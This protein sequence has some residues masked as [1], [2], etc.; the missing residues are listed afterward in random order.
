MK[1]KILKSI[2]VIARK[3]AEGDVNSTCRFWS[4]QP[5]EPETAKKLRKF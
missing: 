4:Y 2:A 5:K 1:K 3:A